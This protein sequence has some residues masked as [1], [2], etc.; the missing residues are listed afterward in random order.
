MQSLPFALVPGTLE[1]L[2]WAIVQLKQNYARL[3]HR[4]LVG[5][6]DQFDGAF[7]MQ[8]NPRRLKPG[9]AW[10]SSSR[11]IGIHVHRQLEALARGETIVEP[12]QFTRAIAVK[13]REL[14]WVAVDSEVPIVVEEIDLY[15]RA[16][17]LLFDPVENVP[18]I[19]EIKTGRDTGYKAR[20]VSRQ[21]HIGLPGKDVYDSHHTRAHVQ[22]G[23]M[24]A[25]LQSQFAIPNLKAVVIVANA[26]GAKPE[27]LAKWAKTHYKF[28]YDEV[29]RT[30]RRQLKKDK[31]GVGT[32]AQRA[33][34]ITTQD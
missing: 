11:Q 4:E 32:S 21:K 2:Q 16:D 27:N 12:H 33:L 18:I 1:Y 7:G 8:K 17:L 34:S 25:A 22:L 15:T 30:R 14:G 28:I 31:T 23:W 13:I 10:T 29:V 5:L 6:L 20:L 9:P 26:R 24:V 19:V 3:Q